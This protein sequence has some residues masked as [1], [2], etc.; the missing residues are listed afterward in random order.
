[1]ELTADT[2]TTTGHY[3]KYLEWLQDPQ[4]QSE[5]MLQLEDYGPSAGGAQPA[6]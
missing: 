6:S 5:A 1:M 2:T 3:A 4:A